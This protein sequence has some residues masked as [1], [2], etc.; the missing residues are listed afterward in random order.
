MGIFI[1]KPKN[2]RWLTCKF[3][4]FS[5]IASREFCHSFFHSILNTFQKDRDTVAS[6]CGHGS[7]TSASIPITQGACHT[8]AGPYP[9]SLDRLY[10]CRSVVESE[11][12]EVAQSCPTLCNPMDCSLPGSS[13]HGTGRC[14]NL[15]ATREATR[16]S[17]DLHFNFPGDANAVI[18]RTRVL[19]QRRHWHPTPVLLPGESHWWR[20]LVG[21]SPQGR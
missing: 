12:S 14:F 15:W 7:P 17:E 3:E 16:G 6:N 18:G 20:S 1:V 5:C 9:Q 13:L 10:F 4:K 21:C 11:E 19:E 8:T 2:L